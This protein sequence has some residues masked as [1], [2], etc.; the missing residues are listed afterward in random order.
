MNKKDIEQY[1][2]V[3][4]KVLT[5][6]QVIQS[7]F[8]N[9]IRELEESDYILVENRRQNKTMVIQDIETFTGVKSTTRNFKLSVTNV[10]ENRLLAK[11]FIRE[12]TFYLM[13][14]ESKNITFPNIEN[15]LEPGLTDNGFDRQITKQL[16][17]GWKFVIN[18]IQDCNFNMFLSLHGIVAKE[19]A[20]EW[21]VL[22][23]GKV[24]ISGTSHIP[25]IPTKKMITNL[26]DEFNK[27]KDKYLSAAT[28]LVKLIKMQPFWDGNKRTSFLIVNKLLIENSLGLL[29]LKIEHFNEFNLLLNTFYNDEQ[30][31][32][33]LTTFIVKNC[34]YNTLDKKLI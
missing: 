12:N 11:T 4:H 7:S 16:I 13:R 3:K 31:L 30:K 34:F 28:L 18:N 20:L 22:R 9:V 29:T 8:G 27:S 33:E 10:E 32:A 1:K 19:Q 5:T 15:Y 26:F 25:N 17:D 23:S 2:D 14:F 21:G 6:S 24:T